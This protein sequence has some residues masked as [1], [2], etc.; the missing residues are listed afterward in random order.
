LA[1][2]PKL[3]DVSKR[4]PLS[5][6]RAP[7]PILLTAEDVA[8][9]TGL[10]VETLAQWRSQKRGIPYIKLSRNVIRYRQADLENFLEAR[11]VRVEPFHLGR[12][13]S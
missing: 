5:D 7:S 11:I 12:R 6:S 3:V 1:T 9:V 8:Q 10:S 4:T 2:T 13:G